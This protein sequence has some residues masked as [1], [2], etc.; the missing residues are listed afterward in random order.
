M[1]FVIDKVV[2]WPKKS[3]HSFRTV[4]FK[5]DKINIITGASRTGKSA[6]IPIIDYCLGAD[7]CTIPVDTIRNATAWFGVLISLDGG[8]ILLCRKEPGQRAS[9]GEMY[10]LRGNELSIPEKIIAN[11]TV[12]EVKNVLNELFSMSFLAVDPQNRDGFSS[13]PSYRDFMAF[14]FQPQN[15]VANA[16]VMFYKADTM[17]HRQRLINIFPYALGAVTPEILAAR[18]E[19]E[20]VKKQRDRLQR[21]LDAI[22]EVSENWKQEISSWLMQAKEMGLIDGIDK[23]TTFEEQVDLLSQVVERSATDS[24]MH[25]TNIR[26]LSAELV[27]LRKEE[28]SLSS[29]LFALQTRYTEMLQLKDSL[30]D[31]EGSLKIQ[32]Q[33]LE[34]STWL[35]ELATTTG[36]CPFCNSDHIEAKVE[37]DALCAAIAEI[38]KSADDIKAMPAAFDRELHLVQKDIDELVEKLTAVRKRIA[39]ESGKIASD[40]D[41]KYTLSSISRFLGR[42]ETSLQTF[43]KIG[44][45]GELERQ[46]LELIA[47]IEGLSAIVNEAQ[48][49]SKIN[50]AIS[51]INQK[52]GEI[53]KTLD[54]EHP[55]D[56]V[57][58]LDKDLTIKVRSS[59]GRDDYLWEIGS[60]SNWLA[61]HL[62]TILA[63]QNFFQIRGKVAVPNF[64]VFDQPSQVYFPQQINTEE[65]KTEIKDEDKEA[66]RKIF[67][68]IDS[69]LKQNNYAVQIIITEHA[70]SD[71]WGNI[72][73]VHLVERW[74]GNKKLIPEEWL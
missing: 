26:D 66:V 20:R 57:Q 10:I 37:L 45:D 30:G 46:I 71:I 28:Q 23:A 73:A 5:S 14:L 39:V 54:A 24:L 34:I 63:F 52:I 9:T 62:A 16:D 55:D 48:I 17:E 68:A 53:V 58:F 15:I 50:A 61:Y 1:K 2:L 47:R 22:K 33:R 72:E 18:Q 51:Y 42:M 4:D 74:R 40:S 44:R 8:Q 38:E 19:L 7:K 70:D 12:D 69:Y 35:K 31:Y 67:T 49:R 6:I 11:T 13:R 59:S 65:E 60:A 3:E 25:S 64:V 41:K 56:P 36:T 21:E 32:L 43:N 27:F 29:K